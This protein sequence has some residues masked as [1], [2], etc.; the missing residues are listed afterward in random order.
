MLSRTL[1]L[2]LLCIVMPCSMAIGKIT[3]S[4]L[5]KDKAVVIID[6]TQR[7]LTIGKPSPEGVKLISANSQET[8]LEIDGIQKT[9]TL[10]TEI[11]RAGQPT[12][13]AQRRYLAA[14][15]PKRAR[16]P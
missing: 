10:G 6:G 8:V 12:T 1:L 5:F 9:Y 16:R 14:Q 11:S 13:D 2:I 7:I 15:R 4:G 3:I